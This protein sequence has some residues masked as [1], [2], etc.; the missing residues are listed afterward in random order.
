MR[1]RIASARRTCFDEQN[2]TV[3]MLNYIQS[4]VSICAL[5]RSMTGGCSPLAN[6]LLIVIKRSGPSP[7]GF[8]FHSMV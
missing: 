5:M 7:G 6:A 4:S 3:L 2:Q 8:I 1:H